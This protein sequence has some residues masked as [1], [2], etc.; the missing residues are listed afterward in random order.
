M[1]ANAKKVMEMEGVKG[2]IPTELCESCMAGHQE[3]EIS[4][5]LIPKATEFLGRLHVDIEGS[6]PVTFSG[7]RYFLSIKDDAW[8]MFFILPMKTKGEIYDKLVDIWTWIE[9]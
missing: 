2:P 3:L 7:F 1:V 4:R 6:L 8:G 5:R 9:N